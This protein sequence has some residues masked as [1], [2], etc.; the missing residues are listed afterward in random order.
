MTGSDL[1]NAFSGAVGQFVG[2]ATIFPIDVTKI[3]LMST[4][5]TI[6]QPWYQLLL[7]M[8]RDDGVLGIYERFPVKGFQ[9]ASTRFSYYYLYAWLSRLVA[10]N[11]NVESL[12]FWSNLA[13]GYV[14]G[15]V[16]MLPSNPL[17]VVSTVVMHSAERASVLSVVRQI[18]QTEGVL[19]FWK[20]CELSI[21]TAM[22]PAIQN[23]LFDQLKR[24]WL[25]RPGR[26]RGGERRLYLT[27]LESFVLGAFAKAVATMATH[28][29]SRAKVMTSTRETR[30]VRRSEE[31]ERTIR[32]EKRTRRGMVCKSSSVEESSA[33]PPPR[34]SV[35]LILWHVFQT[36]GVAGL[37]Q[38]IM[39]SLTKSVVQSAIML[40]VKEKVDEYSRKFIMN[41]VG[42]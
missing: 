30:S 12:G 36:K 19:G 14:I 1:A 33:S 7:Q 35:L 38:G 20:G 26:R 37:Y 29:F 9:Q 18:Y 23:T 27:V 10:T 41:L 21:V 8:F 6:T 31:E 22:N 34:K 17:E 11:G 42:E 15:V 13:V 24:W 28:P 40:L 32:R 3:K 5:T 2:S 4:T 39:P 16:N 25:Q